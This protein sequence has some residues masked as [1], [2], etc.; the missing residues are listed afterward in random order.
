MNRRTAGSAKARRIAIL[1][2]AIALAP[3]AA[4]A[5]DFIFLDGFDPTRSPI[6]GEIIFT[7]FMANPAVVS[8]NVGEW[9]EVFNTSTTADLELGGCTL[10]SVPHGGLDTLPALTVVR[11]QSAVYVHSADTTM[12][13]GVHADAAFSYSLINGISDTL[14]FSC[15]NRVIDVASFPVSSSSEGHAWSLGP[16]AYDSVMNDDASHWCLAST[17]FGSFN[18]FGSPGS[19]NP[20]CN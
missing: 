4:R 5:Q 6:P 12:N 18:N 17:S 20:P 19:V 1:L 8:D 2:G 10:T 9:F 7:E 11:G 3:L 15:N 13:G 14:A 16:V